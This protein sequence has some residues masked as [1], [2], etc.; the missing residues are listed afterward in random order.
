MQLE[1]I[2]KENIE[3]RFYEFGGIF[4]HVF[5]CDSSVLVNILMAKE[6]SINNANLSYVLKGNNLD[7]QNVSHFICQMIVNDQTFRTYTLD[8]INNETHKYISSLLIKATQDE[9]IQCL[10][11]NMETG[12]METV[13]PKF[14]EDSIFYM[15][16]KSGISWEFEDANLLENE[17]FVKNKGTYLLNSSTFIDGLIPSFSEMQLKALYYS[18]NP[19]HKAIEAIL[20][21]SDLEVLVFQMKWSISKIYVD[22]DMLDIIYKNYQVPEGTKVMYCLFTKPS[23]TNNFDSQEY[24]IIEYL[25]NCY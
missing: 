16:N 6:N 10:K 8:F 20:K 24:F 22:F 14:F 25:L 15:I 17:N 12:Y 9:R 19:K 7:P 1:F 18:L 3:N 13:C 4:R 23:G 21:L 2:S 11:R 5:C